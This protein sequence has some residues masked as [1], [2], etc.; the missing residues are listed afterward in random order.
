MW[1][2]YCFN[3]L[4]LNWVNHIKIDSKFVS[5]YKILVSDPHKLKSIGWRSIKDICQVADSM[6]EFPLEKMN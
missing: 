1:I 3:K 5:E 6:I 4:G 2:E